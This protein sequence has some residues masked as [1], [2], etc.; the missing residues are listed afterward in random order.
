MLEKLYSTHI[1]TNAIQKTVL[2]IGSACAAISN[3]A[4]GGNE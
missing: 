2:A 4:R 1:P 3:P